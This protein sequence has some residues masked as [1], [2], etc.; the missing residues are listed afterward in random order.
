M[1]SKMSLDD[2]IIPEFSGKPLFFIGENLIIR[3]WIH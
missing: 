1:G 3:K 2:I